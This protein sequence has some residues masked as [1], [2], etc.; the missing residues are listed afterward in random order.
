MSA[1]VGGGGH[2]GRGIAVPGI[3]H[4]VRWGRLKTVGKYEN[5]AGGLGLLLTRDVR[6]LDPLGN[7]LA[8]FQLWRIETLAPRASWRDARKVARGRGTPRTPGSCNDIGNSHLGRGAGN[9]RAVR[10]N[11][12]VAPWNGG[13][14][15]KFMSRK[16]VKEFGAKQDRP[17]RRGLHP[18]PSPGGL[19]FDQ[20][21]R[22]ARKRR[23]SRFGGA[24]KRARGGARGPPP[25]FLASSR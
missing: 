20:A 13:S 24:P 3:T 2:A 11:V 4:P 23:C 25:D 22:I 8:Q 14:S 18:A 9:R 21:L 5:E 7:V 19:G 1:E 15:G 12:G 10:P 16:S 17:R 6:S